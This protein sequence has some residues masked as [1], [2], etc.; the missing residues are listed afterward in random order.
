MSTTP[1]P[2]MD[3]LYML[4]YNQQPVGHVVGIF[5]RN[6]GPSQIEVTPDAF[7]GNGLRLCTPS[8]ASTVAVPDIADFVIPASYIGLL[9]TGFQ[10][11]AIAS[12]L[13]YAVAPSSGAPNA[14]TSPLLAAPTIAVS[15]H[16]FTISL[17]GTSKYNG[18][19]LILFVAQGTPAI[20]SAPI[21]NNAN[22]IAPTLPLALS[23]GTNY[24]AVVFVPG[25]TIAVSAGFPG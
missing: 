9:A 18:S 24:R 1:Q 23:S 4:P 15:P 10:Y 16:P 7:L 25:F 3:V 19:I 11:P 12:P 22:S 13:L 21:M 6:S 5:T 2:Q 17:P 14:V 20:P 8:T